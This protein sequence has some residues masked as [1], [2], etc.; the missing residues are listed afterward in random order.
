MK[1]SQFLPSQLSS[2]SEYALII[3]TGASAAVSLAAQQVTAASLPLTALVAIGLLNRHRL[4]QKL[5]DHVPTAAD[6]EAASIEVLP[7]STQ[8]I[9]SQPTPESSMTQPYSAAFSSGDVPSASASPQGQTTVQFSGR[10]R[11]SANPLTALQQESL[12]KI[13]AYLQ[14]VREAKALSLQDIHRQTFIQVYMLNA[15]EIGALQRLPEPFYVRAFISKYAR[16][17]G[18][19]GREIAAAFPVDG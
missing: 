16:V 17:L 7:T 2:A 15:I 14:Q 10:Y 4:D 12:Y 5:K 19:D 9:L 13:G 6:T 8:P 1:T 11:Q 3:G 18:L